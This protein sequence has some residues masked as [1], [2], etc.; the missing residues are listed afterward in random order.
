VEYLF[1]ANGNAWQHG[2]MAPGN[3]RR[4][5]KSLKVWMDFHLQIQDGQLGSVFSYK[6]I[7][8]N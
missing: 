8:H 6:N 2:N 1:G 7:A 3:G 5:D 4:D